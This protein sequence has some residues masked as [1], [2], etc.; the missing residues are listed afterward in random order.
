MVDDLA[1]LE[2]RISAGFDYL[3]EREVSGKMDAHYSKWF[4]EWVR[5][6]ED[7]QYRLTHCRLTKAE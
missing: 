6:L 7:Y 2:K 3:F 1:T 5:L 4:A